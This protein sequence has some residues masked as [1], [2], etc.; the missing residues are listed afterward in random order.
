MKSFL[1]F[2]L[3]APLAGAV[4]EPSPPF[5]PRIERLDPAFDGLVAPDARIE[6]L[7]EGFRWSEG[8]VWIDGAVIFPMCRTTLPTA[9]G[10]A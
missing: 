1:L 6:I 9:G 10:P 7:A 4:A 8:P 2:L 3:M 5:H